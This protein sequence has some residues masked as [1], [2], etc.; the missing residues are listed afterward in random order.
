MLIVCQYYRMI[1]GLLKVAIVS[2]WSLKNNDICNDILRLIGQRPII[3]IKN[4]T[5]GK[6]AWE[7]FLLIALDIVR[8]LLFLVQLQSFMMENYFFRLHERIN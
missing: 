3:V 5:R 1:H 2:C 7:I 4:D 8:G 6:A